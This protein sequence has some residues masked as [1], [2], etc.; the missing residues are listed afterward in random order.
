[1]GLVVIATGRWRYQDAEHCAW[2]TFHLHQSRLPPTALDRFKLTHRRWIPADLADRKNTP[3]NP[4]L[5]RGNSV[6]FSVMY[7][8][9]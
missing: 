5:R 8:Y 9:G 6:M 2:F 1:M 4:I 3:D 7:W